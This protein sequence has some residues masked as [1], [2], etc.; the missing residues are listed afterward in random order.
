MTLTQIDNHI[1]AT[2]DVYSNSKSDGK[3][4]IKIKKGDDAVTIEL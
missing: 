4:K 1:D 3:I 2:A